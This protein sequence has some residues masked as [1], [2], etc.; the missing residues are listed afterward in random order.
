MHPEVARATVLKLPSDDDPD[1]TLYNLTVPGI[2]KGYGDVKVTD[3]GTP[4]LGFFKATPKRYGIGTRLLLE[5][6]SDLTQLGYD[7]IHGEVVH[8]DTINL[9]TDFIE[10]SRKAGTKITIPRDKFFSLP[11]V[12]FM[13]S[14]HIKVH[15]M[16]VEYTPLNADTE[17]NPLYYQVLYDAEIQ[18]N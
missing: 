12:Q 5:V 10:A 6:A 3:Y 13:R 17:Q 4:E 9:L 7:S 14:G 2:G 11:V 8:H 1:R 18:H 15:A 16:T